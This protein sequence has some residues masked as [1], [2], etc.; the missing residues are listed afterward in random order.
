MSP[1]RGDRVAPPPGQ[2]GWDI[3]FITNEAVDGW[4]DLS[5]Q[6]PGATRTAWEQL[7]TDPRRHDNRQ[8]RMA[9]SL[10]SGRYR[11]VLLEQWEYEVASAA[12]IRYLID[13]SA[14]TVRLV[15]AR[16][17]HFKDTE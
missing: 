14:R 10:G 5:S 11:G 9:G 7:T 6:M 3:A 4:R 2:G 8:H 13:D 12:R 15:D 17:S 16:V 1:K